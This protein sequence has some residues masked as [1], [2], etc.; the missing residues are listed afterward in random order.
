MK[1]R[2]LGFVAYPGKPDLIGEPIEAATH[3]LNMQSQEFE[4]KTW[5]ALDVPGRFIAE[6]VLGAIEK[7]DCFVADITYLNFNVI[8]EIGYAIGKKKG[9]LLIRN[10]TLEGEMNSIQRVGIFDTLAYIDYQNSRE[11]QTIL[12]DSHSRTPLDR[13]QN[14]NSRV[15]LY[16]V[17]AKHK[18]DW[19]NG[20]VSRVKRTRL[21]YRSF[22][23][24][25]QPRLS[26]H[27]AI[28]QV[29]QSYGVLSQLLSRDIR[30]HD[31]HNLRAA[32]ISGLAAG[33]NKPIM[34]IQY[35]DDP[36]PIDYRD[37]VRTCYH[38]KDL[39]EAV[40]DFA[41][42]VTQ[43]LQEEL[44][45][46]VKTHLT[47]LEKLDLG[48]SSAE[49]EL[50]YLNFYYVETDG[51]RRAARGEARLVVGRKGAGKT[52]VFMQIRER[53]G[54]SR[55]NIVLDLKPDGYKL[56]KFKDTVL[57]LLER[58]SFEHTVMAFWEYI[59]L[60][61]IRHRILE[62]DRAIHNNDHVL[63]EPYRRL[64]ELQVDD[65]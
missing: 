56:L 24:S 30:D 14:L 33:M 41:A 9:V 45:C 19:V 65:E 32:F 21:N 42:E 3:G 17:D 38:I 7:C 16:F 1:K 44:D 13:P 39:D 18:T 36:V 4:F 2:I 55:K 20:L 40:T 12:R 59:L 27:D 58:G 26:A 61:E 63:Y 50:R 47:F 10:S 25:E 54:K 57:K 60:L 23:P 51:F 6:E 64:S 11:L 5:K 49:N 62:S 15:P 8:Y 43:A 48:A 37:L 46:V 53:V 34:I 28:N 31:V 29:A 22:D 35:K 52:A